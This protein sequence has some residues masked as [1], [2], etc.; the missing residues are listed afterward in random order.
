M[1]SRTLS[2]SLIA[3]G[4]IALA[5]CGS[6]ELGTCDALAQLN[7]VEGER[8]ALV[9]AEAGAARADDPDAISSAADARQEAEGRRVA[10]LGALDDAVGRDAELLGALSRL[11]ADWIGR[12][13]ADPEATA[14]A[15]EAVNAAY[16]TTCR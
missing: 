13:G 14:A 8:T 6:D 12:P 1:A 2:L 16:T 10:A 4:L 9:A 7:A 11:R 5:G 3:A 15:L